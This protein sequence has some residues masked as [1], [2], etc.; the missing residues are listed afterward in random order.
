MREVFAEV[1]IVKR[2]MSERVLLVQE[3]MKSLNF[4]AKKLRSEGKKEKRARS[5]FSC[6]IES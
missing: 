1:K 5:T 2:E 6:T 4:I 3:F